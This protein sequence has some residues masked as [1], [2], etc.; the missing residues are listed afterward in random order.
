MLRR[1]LD[2]ADAD[3]AALKE[4]SGAQ[5][6]DRIR[7]GGGPRATHGGSR[8]CGLWGGGGTLCAGSLG[9]AAAVFL[10]PQRPCETLD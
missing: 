1:K 7:G 5:A 8:A 6:I 4:K 10:L 9:S 3:N 2:A